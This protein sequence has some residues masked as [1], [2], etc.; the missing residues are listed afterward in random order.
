MAKILIYEDSVYDV[1]DRYGSLVGQ[2]DVQLRLITA[3]S[4]SARPFI[5]ETGF[6]KETLVRTD[7]DMNKVQYELGEPSQERADV[8]FVDGLKGFCM[9]LLPQLPKNR[10]FLNSDDYGLVEEAKREGF[11]IFGDWNGLTFE[12][13]IIRDGLTD[14]IDKGGNE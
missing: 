12:E 14:L 9:I 11:R 1:K 7:F 6:D 5:D 8:Y 10:A 2:H 13:M 4:Y 3:D